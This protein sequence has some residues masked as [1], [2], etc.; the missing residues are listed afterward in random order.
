VD[1]ML[2]ELRPEFFFVNKKRV[3]LAYIVS[4]EEQN[5]MLEHMDYRYFAPEMTLGT[6]GQFTEESNVFALG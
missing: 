2:Y 3:K 5:D 4:R 6:N 1:V